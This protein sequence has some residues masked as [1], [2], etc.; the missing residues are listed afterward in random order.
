M[1][2]ISIIISKAGKW[3]KWENVPIQ[4]AIIKALS[5]FP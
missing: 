1:V 5:I 4:P 2:E 3:G